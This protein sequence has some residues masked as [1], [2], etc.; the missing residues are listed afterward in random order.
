MNI[1]GVGTGELLL[2]MV[3]AML[4]VGPEKLAGFARQAGQFVAKIR[5]LTDD[6]SLDFREALDEVDLKGAVDEITGEAAM[7][8]EA[9]EG[10]EASST[11]TLP[12]GAQAALPVPGE[13]QARAVHAAPADPARYEA[14]RVRQTLAAHLADGE[15]EVQPGPDTQVTGPIGAEGEASGA[16]ATT[17]EV[18]ALVP[19][20]Q[21]VPPVELGSAVVV[22]EETEPIAIGGQ[23]LSREV[24]AEA[25]RDEAVAVAAC[26][27]GSTA[28]VNSV[29]AA[30]EPARL[31]TEQGDAHSE[32]PHA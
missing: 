23:E 31:P 30:A 22:A 10:V 6:V 2:V 21:D 25:S 27:P 4:V 9:I 15:I 26:S 18:G 28:S 16:V 24:L 19:E 14:E 12:S 1:F 13:A 5:K 11:G 7:V 20:D 32:G 17:I 8:V 3:I 29:P